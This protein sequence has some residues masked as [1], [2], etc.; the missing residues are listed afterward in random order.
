[1]EEPDVVSREIY[2]I[3]FYLDE[4]R[5]SNKQILTLV[6]E[7]S[8]N[9]TSK[10][11]KATFSC[12]KKA[13]VRSASSKQGVDTKFNLGSNGGA[14]PMVVGDEV[15]FSSKISNTEETTVTQ[16]YTIPPRTTVTA[17]IVGM[18]ARCDVPYSYKQRDVLTTGQEVTSIRD[19]GIYTVAKHYNFAVI[20]TGDEA[21]KM[22]KGY[23]CV[24]EDSVKTCRGKKAKAA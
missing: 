16:E 4:G 21:V 22:E 5:V 3:R 10:E 11:M 17:K 9:D 12:V 23:S 20:Y 1:V 8:T 18:R 2:D 15:T 13:E 6:T 7:Y 14:N 19:D 24:I